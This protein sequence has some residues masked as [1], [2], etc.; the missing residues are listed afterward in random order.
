M[1]ST[2]EGIITLKPKPRPGRGNRGG[3]GRGSKSTPRDSS[4]SRPQERG[5]EDETMT[6]VQDEEDTEGK[7][8]CLVCADVIRYEAVY[9][10]NHTVCH[11]CALRLRALMKDNHCALCRTQQEKIVI[12]EKEGANFNDFTD[13]Q[14]AYQEP[15][16]GVYFEDRQTKDDVLSLLKLKCPYKGC[17]EVLHNWKELKHHVKDA[18][19]REFCD[20]CT[21]H[22]KAF[23]VEFPLYTSWG[24]QKHQKDGDDKTG[25]T[26]HPRCGFCRMYF[27]SDEELFVHCREKHERC[28]ICDRNRVNN[29]PEHNY[30]RDY[31]NLEKHF[32][33]QHYACGVQFCLDKKFVVF[34]S[35]LELQDH[36][37]NTHPEIVGTSRQA[38]IVETNFSFGRSGTSGSGFGSQ[39]STFTEPVPA[40]AG[41]GLAASTATATT[42]ISRTADSFPALG[43]QRASTPTT[44]SPQVASVERFHANAPPGDNSPA[45]MRRRLEERARMYLNYDVSKFEKFQDIN[46]EFAAGTIDGKILIFEYSKLFVD[47]KV[48][49]MGILVH[50]LQGIYKTKSSQLEKALQSWVDKQ[51]PPLGQQTG[52]ATSNMLSS[53]WAASRSS[54]RTGGLAAQDFPSL[55]KSASSGKS[56]TTTPMSKIVRNT[57]NAI[58]V[59][60]SLRSLT[61]NGDD[62]GTSNDNTKSTVSASASASPDYSRT[63]SSSSLS[64]SLF[65]SL[66]QSKVK[67]YPLNR[68][69]TTPTPSVWD[70]SS[71]PSQSPTDPSDDPV[72]GSNR[73][74]KGR[75]KQV[76]YN[77]GAFS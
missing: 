52:P 3:G 24:L 13:E 32:R 2:E 7:E 16:Y 50:E 65:P 77:L 19:N 71:Q 11:R 25:F 67:A 9:P 22:K 55:P 35:K 26:G 51:S 54:L 48:S 27:Y 14:L 56:R 58:G 61:L 72:V 15:R 62:S 6:N 33:E 66:P 40:T 59:T 64:D 44:N 46:G 69:G 75:K 57:P 34:D 8:I 70:P 47:I 29:R 68:P 37:I 60:K 20:I 5:K 76:L 49:E 21:R 41:N 53:T 4:V 43:T 45:T 28:F 12:T 31:E 63:S 73:K 10:C 38:R 36:M 30:Y 39:L 17:G 74:Q 42:T 18:H 23:T 1:A